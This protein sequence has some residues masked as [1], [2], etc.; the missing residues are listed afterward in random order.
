MLKVKRSYE[1]EKTVNIV[2]VGYAALRSRAVSKLTTPKVKFRGLN[3]RFKRMDQTI[4]EG[5]ARG[6]SLVHSREPQVQLFSIVKALIRVYV[7]I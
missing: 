1:R 6:I 5:K 7:K 2:C 3:L 4:P